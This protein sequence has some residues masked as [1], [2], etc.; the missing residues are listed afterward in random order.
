MQKFNQTF[1]NLDVFFDFSLKMSH[2]DFNLPSF[3]LCWV[4]L[5]LCEHPGWH[6]KP[7]FTISARLSKCY[8]PAKRFQHSESL[9]Y[10]FTGVRAQTIAL[11]KRHWFGLLWSRW[12]EPI[13]PVKIY[14]EH[15]V[16]DLRSKLQVRIQSLISMDADSKFTVSIWWSILGPNYKYGSRVKIHYEH[17]V[18]RSKLQVWSQTQDSL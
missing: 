10:C 13:R 5:F 14:C 7:T 15:L 11:A 1:I 17:L 9:D 4:L 6:T 3:H 12:Q 2:Q 16:I 18:I 8:K